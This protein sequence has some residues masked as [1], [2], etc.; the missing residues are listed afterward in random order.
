MFTT[1]YG[2]VYVFAYAVCYLLFYTTAVSGCDENYFP[3]TLTSDSLTCW[4]ESS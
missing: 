2:I 3:G 4:V 1:T